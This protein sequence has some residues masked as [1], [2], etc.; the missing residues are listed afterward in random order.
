MLIPAA[1]SL[2]NT[3]LLLPHSGLMFQGAT[4]NV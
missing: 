1:H 3:H 4:K 2:P